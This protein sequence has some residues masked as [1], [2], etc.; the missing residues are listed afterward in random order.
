MPRPE[1]GTGSIYRIAT[2]SGIEIVYYDIRYHVASPFVF[3]SNGRMVE[4]QFALSG[5]RQVMVS[6]QLHELPVGKGA[7]AFMQ[8]FKARF[9][10]PVPERY[11]SLSLGIPVTLFDYAA[12]QLATSLNRQFEF[13]R[14][15]DGKPSRAYYFDIDVRSMAVVK[16]LI[17]DFRNDNRSPLMMEA[18]ALELLNRHMIQLFD[19]TPRPRGLSKDDLQK[20]HRVKQVLESGMADP[21][22]LQ[23]LAKM[24]GLNDFKLKSGFKACFGLTVFEYLRHIRLDYAM[25]LLRNGEANVTEAAMAVGYSNVSAFSEQFFRRYGVKPSEIKNNYNPFDRNISF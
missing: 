23:A 15:L 9:Y 19:L 2:Y 6:D 12:N 10:P 4:L 3:A 18:S 16:Q 14:V 11:V 21:P 25:K 24:A 22:S 13:N 17:S 8:N 7:L 5:Q 20:L 1:V